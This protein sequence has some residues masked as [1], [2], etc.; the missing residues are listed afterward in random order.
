MNKGLWVWPADQ[1][2]QAKTLR[3]VAASRHIMAALGA[4]SKSKGGLSNA[5]LDDAISDNSNWMT[6]W[7]IDQLVSLGFAEYHVD[8]FGGPGKYMLTEL[9][10]RAYGFITGKPVQ[11]AQQ[12]RAAPPAPT[13]QAK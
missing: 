11:Q 10:T 1:R 2:E 4:L 13:P 6:R 8:F 3:R 12:V 7:V 5:Q 9:G